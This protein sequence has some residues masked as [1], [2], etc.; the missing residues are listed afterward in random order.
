MKYPDEK[1]PLNYLQTELSMEEG[2]DLVWGAG[3]H[4][5]RLQSRFNE[6]IRQEISSHIGY[7]CNLLGQLRIDNGK[8]SLLYGQILGPYEQAINRIE[9]SN[10]DSDFAEDCEYLQGLMAIE[11]C[12]NLSF[13]DLTSKKE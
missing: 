12:L 7:L 4:A 5:L 3:N 13:P 8:R 10:P 1:Y 11:L 6:D 2:Y 9:K